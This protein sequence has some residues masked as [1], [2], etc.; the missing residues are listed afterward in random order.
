M[1]ERRSDS[2]T[3]TLSLSW[4]EQWTLHHVLLH[5]L[6][7]DA[8][9]EAPTNTDAPSIELSQ[10]FET[11]DAGETTFTIDQ[12]DATQTVLAAYH[13]APS[14]DNERSQ[15]EQLL[16]RVTTALARASGPTAAD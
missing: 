11:L 9:T 4:A 7:P 2:R 13:H 6:D 10:A 14:W 16:H 15:L 1:T 12:L 5:R 3:V 8:P